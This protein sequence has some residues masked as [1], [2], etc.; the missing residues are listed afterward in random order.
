MIEVLFFVLAGTVSGFALGLL[1]GFHINNFLPMLAAVPF[2]PAQAFSFVVPASIAFCFSSAF[3]AILLGAPNSDTAVTILPAHRLVQEGRA[4]TALLISSY[5]SLLSVIFCALTLAIFLLLFVPIFPFIRQFMPYILILIAGY[6][7]ITGKTAALLIAFL[8]SMLGFA[9]LKYDLLLPLLTGFFGLS[10]LILSLATE[11]SGYEQGSEFVHE[12]SWFEI[13]RASFLASLLGSIFSVVPAVS[14]SI[15]ATLGRV[16][17][18]TEVEEFIAFVSSTN[19][20]YMIFS[21]FALELIGVSRSGSAVFLLKF[22]GANILFL[23]GLILLSGTGAAL[24]SIKIAKPAVA[25]YSKINYR[26]LSVFAVLFL[27]AVNLIF[28]GWFGMLVLFASTSIGLL[29]SSLQV[30]KI[31]CM[32]ALIVPTVCLLI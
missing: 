28:T 13:I 17:G 16:F 29:C 11:S 18:K 4:L 14:S 25:V 23:L 1:P 3:P 22:S 32:F 26:L 5:S 20:T 15:T 9:T 27:L 31:T 8:A 7:L 19:A 24:L 6:L 12:C 30:A 2:A 10:T 21:I